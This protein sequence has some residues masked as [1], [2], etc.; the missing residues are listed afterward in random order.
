M[1][2]AVNT[3]S[4]VG[5]AGVTIVGEYAIPTVDGSANQVIV[6]DGA[7]TTSFQ[8]VDASAAA[9][10]PATSADW[11]TAD[12]TTIKEALDRIAAVVGGV[13]PIP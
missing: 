9:Y 3:D 11:A 12:P 10:T 8:T 1:N 4:S 6:T 7:G 2:Q 13:V 5:F